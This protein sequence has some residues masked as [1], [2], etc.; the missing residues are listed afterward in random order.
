MVS[1]QYYITNLL[2][3]LIIWFHAIYHPKVCLSF[4]SP[5][6]VYNVFTPSSVDRNS[7]KNYEEGDVLHTVL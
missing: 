6:Y 7:S 5:T 2:L 4:F 1:K 3:L